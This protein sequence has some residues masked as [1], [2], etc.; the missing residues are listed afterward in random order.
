MKPQ[1]A[2]FSL[3]P[4]ALWRLALWSV[5]AVALAACQGGDQASRRTALD[6]PSSQG[7]LKRQ[8]VSGDGKTCAYADADGD[9]VSLRLIPVASTPEAALAPIEQELQALV[10]P[11]PPSAP[12]ADDEDGDRADITLPGMR[13]HAAGD[14]ADVKVGSLHVNAADG[15]AVIRE[16][17]MARLRGEQLSLQRRGYRATY[18]VAGQDLPGGLSSIGYEAG[19]PRKGP[20]TVAVLRMKSDNGKVIHRDV[21]RLVRLNGGV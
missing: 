19:G 2:A 1:S 12:A 17:H 7:A 18:I 20:L 15:G 9:E 4:F 21:A 11:V 14:R 10:P 13:I 16:T 3:R 8:S 5:T 6:C